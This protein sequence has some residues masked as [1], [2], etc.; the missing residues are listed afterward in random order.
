M[1]DISQLPP[2]ELRQ[3]RQLEYDSFQSQLAHVRVMQGDYGKWIVASLLLVHG[4]MVALLAQNDQLAVS[5]LVNIFWWPVSG[6]I[7]ALLCGFA[8]WWNWTFAA[9]LYAIPQ[10]GMVYLE[11]AQPQ[12]PAGLGRALNATTIVAVIAGIASVACVLVGAI[13]ASIALSTATIE[14]AHSGWTFSISTS[15]AKS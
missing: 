8:A 3:A 15:L 9:M 4:G 14:P 12:F 7:L 10:A 11:Q 13:H 6:I 1:S 5:V 2:D